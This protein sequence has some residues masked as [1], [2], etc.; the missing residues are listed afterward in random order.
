MAALD[1]E[2]VIGVDVDEVNNGDLGAAK[3]GGGCGMYWEEGATGGKN[4]DDS[5]GLWRRRSL[6][7]DLCVAVK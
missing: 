1:V 2:E 4:E 5:S 6:Q 3:T 7:L